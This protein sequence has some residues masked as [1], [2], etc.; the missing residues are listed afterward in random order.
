M[1]KIIYSL[2]IVFM[3]FLSF[4]SYGQVGNIPYY[5]NINFSDSFFKIAETD[6]KNDYY[7]LNLNTFN[8]EFE[9]SYF[10]NSTFSESRIV[11]I[12]AGN[13][14]IAWFKSNKAFTRTEI[15]GLLISLKQQTISAAGSMTEAE[16]NE[17]LNRNGK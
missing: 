13:P 1:K 12:D 11:R 7:A 6:E 9:K 2:S 14:S 5:N 17:W 4:K 8:S 3:S 10:I 15:A 16:K